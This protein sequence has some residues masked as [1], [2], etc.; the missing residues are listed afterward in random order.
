[1][2]ERGSDRERERKRERA[3]VCETERP[4]CLAPFS[5]V[6]IESEGERGRERGRECV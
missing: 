3:S 5:K 6:A 1:V 4:K 2:R